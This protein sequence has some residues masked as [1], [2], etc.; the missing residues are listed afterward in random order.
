MIPSAGNN[1]QQ[2]DPNWATENW[3]HSG[4][5]GGLDQASRQYSGANGS[6]WEWDPM[7]LAQH[8]GS[9]GSTDGSDGDHKH[10]IS[11]GESSFEQPFNKSELDMV[12]TC[13]NTQSYSL[14]S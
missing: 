9:G 4:A 5:V 7:I 11:V 8:H 13:F 3:D 10:K 1:E 6:E 14:K 12:I 2:G